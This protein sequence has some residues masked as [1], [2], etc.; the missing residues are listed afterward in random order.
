MADEHRRHWFRHGRFL[1]RWGGDG[2]D[3]DL[4]GDLVADEHPAGF[5]GGVPGEAPVLAVD[6]RGGF[7]AEAGVAPGSTAVPVSSTVE[8]GGLGHVLDRQVTGDP[9]VA[10]ST[11]SILVLVKVM[12]G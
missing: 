7:Q 9:E 12:V 11:G 5:E 8:L 4:E 1:S 3:L 2:R 10:S 6:D